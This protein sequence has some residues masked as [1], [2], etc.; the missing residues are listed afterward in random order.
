MAVEPE[1][2]L[3]YLFKE[4]D[5]ALQ[6]GKEPSANE[7]GQQREVSSNKLSRDTTT[8]EG[9]YCSWR[10]PAPVEDRSARER[11]ARDGVDQVLER[12]AR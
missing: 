6:R 11:P 7:S 1:G 8:P 3:A 9:L 12:K 4:E 5:L 10:L 2:A